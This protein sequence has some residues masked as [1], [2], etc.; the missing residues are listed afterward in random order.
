MP[1]FAA[2]GVAA[3]AAVVAIILGVDVVETVGI[4]A[5]VDTVET[6]VAAAGGVM[7]VVRTAMT[8]TNPIRTGTPTPTPTPTAIE[9]FLLLES[10]MHAFIIPSQV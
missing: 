4:S 2:I 7:L 9:L 3:T 5:P 1:A 10:D 8:V 6:T